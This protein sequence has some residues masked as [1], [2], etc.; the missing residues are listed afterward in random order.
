M[1][2]AR[3][4]FF[5]RIHYRVNYFF[6]YSVSSDGAHFSV[7]V[8]SD[9]RSKAFLGIRFQ[10]FLNSDNLKNAV[11]LLPYFGY[12]SNVAQ[13]L[14]VAHQE[15]FKKFSGRLNVATNSLNA[16]PCEGNMAPLSKIPEIPEN[17]SESGINLGIFP[18]WSDKIVIIFHWSVE[19]PQNFQ[20]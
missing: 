7:I 9:S 8:F 17:W 19:M 3:R 12:R 6:R 5:S 14:E 2:N 1:N 18:N 20:V 11:K 10:D 13:A 4:G 15:A 16:N